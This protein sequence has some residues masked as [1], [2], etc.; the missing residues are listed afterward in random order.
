MFI[1]DISTSDLAKEDNKIMRKKKK[2]KRNDN[3]KTITRTTTDQQHIRRLDTL[4]KFSAK[5]DNF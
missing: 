1:S 4:G 3:K 2:K 5:G